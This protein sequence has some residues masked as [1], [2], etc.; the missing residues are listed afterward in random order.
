MRLSG[1]ASLRRTAPVEPDLDPKAAGARVEGF[2]FNRQRLLSWGSAGAVFEAWSTTY[3]HGE[4]RSAHG[5]QGARRLYST[6]LLALRALRCAVEEW[7]NDL[8]SSIDE[9]IR[10]EGGDV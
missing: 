4:G 3:S 8:L 9:A 2:N 6:R 7:A 1:F 5:S 10:E